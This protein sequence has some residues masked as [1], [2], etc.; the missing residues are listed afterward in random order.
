MQFKESIESNLG[1]MMRLRKKVKYELGRLP[2]GTFVQKKSKGH[3]YRYVEI[4]NQRYNLDKHPEVEEQQRYREELEQYDS[5]LLKNIQVTEQCLKEYISL[6]MLFHNWN[7]ICSEENSFHEDSKKHLF[8]DIYFRSKSELAIAM[9]LHS[10]DIEFKYEASFQ[11]QG[12]TVYPDFFIKRPKDNKLFIW[13]HFGMIYEVE[14]RNKMMKKISGYYDEGYRLW[15][16]LI[17]SFDDEGGSID[18]NYIDKIVQL[19]LL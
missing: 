1:F 13:E 5:A 6:P 4:D 9:V 14:Y 12:R 15:D 8:K 7:Q 10:Y 2:K 19:Y 11:N 18:V 3:E 16:N 17:I